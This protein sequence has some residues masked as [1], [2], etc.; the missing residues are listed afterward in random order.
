M[1][2]ETINLTFS[3]AELLFLRDCARVPERMQKMLRSATK[4]IRVVTL[5]LTWDEVR[6]LVN[7]LLA[8]AEAAETEIMGD[9]F[10]AL[11]GRLS[12]ELSI[13]AGIDDY[14]DTEMMQDLKEI[15]QNMIES[16]TLNN[17]DDITGFLRQ[18]VRETAPEP[19]EELHGLTKSAV[20]RLISTSWTAPENPVKLNGGLSMAELEKAE[21]LHDMRAFLKSIEDDGPVKLTAKGNLNR[22]FLQHMLDVMPCFARLHGHYR[23]EV[24]NANEEDIWRM[25]L[26]NLIAKMTKLTRKEKG[27]L[28]LSR[29]GRSLLAED[30]AGE[31][32]KKLFITYFQD[33]NISYMDPLPE[34]PGLQPV[35]RYCLY[36]VRQCAEDWAPIAE[37]STEVLPPGLRREALDSMREKHVQWAV[38][39]R[40]LNIFA[41]FGILEWSPDRFTPEFSQAKMRVTPLFDRFITF[42]L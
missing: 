7:N 37:L 27:R 30:K 25:H 24:V 42:D 40:I 15:V 23:E 16:G 32:Y 13:A 33:Y 36:A 31:L 11:A 8:D 6:L 22:K 20:R 18:K 12:S 4:T 9:T 38:E 2:D 17:F 3:P 21:F 5:E 19:D 28:H 39:V 29:L 1:S 10:L 26:T 14:N 41:I 34:I 35:V